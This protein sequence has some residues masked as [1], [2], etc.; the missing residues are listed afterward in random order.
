MPIQRKPTPRD[1]GK[2]PTMADVVMGMLEVSGGAGMD[3][4]QRFFLRKY[5][6]RVGSSLPATGEMAQ[7]DVRHPAIYQRQPGGRYRA[8]RV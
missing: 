6:N 4:D 7:P 3:R 2:S 5:A 8:R 1:G